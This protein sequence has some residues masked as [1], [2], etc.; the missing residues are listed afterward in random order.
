MDGQNGGNEPVN[1]QAPEGMAGSTN[2]PVDTGAMASDGAMSAENARATGTGAE[3]AGGAVAD[4][5]TAGG[6]AVGGAIFS[7]PNLTIEKDAIPED[8]PASTAGAAGNASRVA[9]AFASTD[10]SQNAAL[11]PSGNGA[12][13]QSTATGDIKLAKTPRKKM[14]KL[15]LIVGIG[16]VAIVAIVVILLM[17]MGGG[18]NNNPR[19]DFETYYKLVVEGPSEVVEE[20]SDDEDEDTEIEEYYGE[21]L[22][23]TITM[24]CDEDEEDCTEEGLVYDTTSVDA[25]NDDQENWYLLRGDFAVMDDEGR[26][27]YLDEVRGS[28]QAYLNS[29]DDATDELRDASLPYHGLLLAVIDFMDIDNIR[30]KAVDEYLTQGKDAAQEYIEGQ[31]PVAQDETAMSVLGSLRVYFDEY[32]ESL[33]YYNNAGCLENDG[34]IDGCSEV[35]YGNSQNIEREENMNRLLTLVSDNFGAVEHSFRVQ[36]KRLK[37]MNDGEEFVEEEEEDYADEVDSNEEIVDISDEEDDNEE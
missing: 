35:V 9:A 16:V 36:T 28:Y 37:A 24:I 26:N 20:T 23:G 15:P 1:P 7:D 6:N 3:A 21:E 33:E 34:E 25:D 13:T 11:A 2:T 22:A 19:G 18:A 12:I 29:L 4:T 10:A 8:V 31:I 27:S 5:E 30:Q 17:T 14:G 32:L